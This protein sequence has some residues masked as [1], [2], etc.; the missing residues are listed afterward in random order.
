MSRIGEVGGSKIA[1]RLVTSG[2]RGILAK[3]A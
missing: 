3:S 1:K 2:V